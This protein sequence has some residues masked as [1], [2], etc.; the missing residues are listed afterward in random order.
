MAPPPPVLDK[1]KK[2]IPLLDPYAE[3]AMDL[4]YGERYAC[5]PWFVPGALEKRYCAENDTLA[6]TFCYAGFP[7][8]KIE[9]KFRGWPV[10]T[11]S[12]TSNIRV[13]TF[14]GTE[15]T[16]TIKGFSRSNAGSY[17]C[18]ATNDHGT[19]EQNV[20]IMVATRPKFIQPLNNRTFTSGKPMRLDVRVEGEPFPTITW[21]KVRLGRGST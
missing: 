13:A 1:N 20:Q 12:P 2:V 14:A 18:V 15:T 17:T 11:Q 9:W 5:A 16:M 8:P 6:V 21:M 19:A 4:A 10:D 3:R 7:D